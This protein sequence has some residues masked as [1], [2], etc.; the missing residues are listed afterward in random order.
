MDQSKMSRLAVLKL[1]RDLTCH[2]FCFEKNLYL[3]SDYVPAV[4]HHSIPF[5]FY[6]V[7][8]VFIFS[9]NSVMIYEVGKVSLQ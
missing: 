5:V 8:H 2:S 6:F 9:L 4:A 1:V 7:L 3:T